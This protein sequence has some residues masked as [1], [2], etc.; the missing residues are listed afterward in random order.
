[1]K[2]SVFGIL[3]FTV[4]LNALSQNSVLTT[5]N[6]YKINTTSNGVYKISYTDLQSYGI[7]PSGIDPRNIKLFGNGNGM[8]PE[9]NNAPK[10]NDLQEIAIKI[11]GE[12]DGVF[13]P[14]DYIL[15]YGQSPDK[16]NFDNTTQTYSHKKNIYTNNV[17]YFITVGSTNGKRIVNQNSSSSTITHTTDKFDMLIFHELDSINLIQSGRKWL[18]EV[19]D[20]PLN[21]TYNL[22]NVDLSALANLSVF[23]TARSSSSSQINVVVDG[24][25]SSLNINSIVASCYSCKYANEGTTSIN[26][27]PSSTTI[28]IDLSYTKP[29]STSVAWLDYFELIT[30]NNLS[31]NNN[32]LLFRDKNSVGNGNITK[33]QIGNTLSSDIIWEI[34]NQNNVVE[35]NK[36]FNAGITEFILNTDSLKEFVVFDLSNLLIPTFEGQVPNQN[37]HGISA[38]DMVI[39]THPNFI[40]AANSLANFHLT[41]DGLTTEIVTTEQVY[42]EFSSGVQDIT[43]INDFMEYLYHQPSSSLKYLLLFGDASYDYKNR[44]N[45]NTNFVPSYQTKNSL[46]VI[47]SIVSDD[48]YALL[49]SNEGTWAGTEF[50]DIAVGRLPVKTTQ[51]ATDVVNKIIYYKTNLSSFGNWRKTL[52]FIGDDEDG[53]NHMA[54]TDYLTK[55]VDTTSCESLIEKIYFDEYQQVVIGTQQS[56]PEVEQKIVNSFRRGSL[57]INYTGHGGNSVLAHE[58]VFNASSIDTLNNTNYPLMILASSE[59][60]RFDEPSFTSLGEKFLLTPNAGSI[61]TFATTRL[62]F[63]SPNFALN[64]SVYNTIFDKINGKHQTLGEVFRKVK[65]LNATNSNNRNFTLLGDPALTLN[66][67]EF[68]I[69]AIHPDTLSSNT[70]N[71][72]T[73]QIEDENGAI[74]TWFNG[75]LIVFVQ[76]KKDTIITLANDGGAPFTFYDRRDTVIYDTV[77]VINGLFNYNLNLTNAQQHI[78]GDAIIN[79][80]AF[81]ANADATGCKDNVF[82]NDILAGINAVKATEVNATVFP[83]PSSGKVSISFREEENETYHFSIYN[84]VGQLVFEEKLSTNNTFTFSVENFKNGIY[85]YQLSNNTNKLTSGK[86][87]VQH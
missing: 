73:G 86:L 54:Q 44:I 8:L 51:E 30:R 67:P 62:S 52:T 42:N 59:S 6:W 5:G 60:S 82:V 22:P 14:S 84:N 47:G 64:Q 83:N 65:N 85:F 74:Q 78:V 61:A 34:S 58:N 79:Y 41:N 13:D 33:F 56:Y 38:P 50:L 63:S 20:N 3:L 23:G 75:N 81:N 72:I 7:N 46:D 27:I 55:I 49:D 71:F 57:I 4:T 1:M 45:P 19:I 24:N 70:S 25:T 31:K 10:T 29:N 66:F 69:N 36:T 11:I 32:Q 68:V 48:Y 77:S 76:G 87:V 18:G 40:A 80:Y 53:N 15:F 37:L 35:Q 43:A 2:N 17:S 39:V 26:F 12:N 21:F 16:W 9:A 28:S